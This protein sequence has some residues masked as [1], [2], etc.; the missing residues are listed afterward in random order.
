MSGLRGL[1]WASTLDWVSLWSLAE[2][3]PAYP[4]TCKLLNARTSCAWTQDLTRLPLRSSPDLFLAFTKPGGP[5]VMPLPS[6][7]YRCSSM[8]R[9]LRRRTG[10]QN[11]KA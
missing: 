6:R 4:I 8:V 3:E 1:S 9:R 10:E 7:S 11:G 5:K 2:A